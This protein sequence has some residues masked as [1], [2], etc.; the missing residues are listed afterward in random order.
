MVVKTELCSFSG[1]KIYPGH[2][3]RL[4]R[5]DGRQ[6]TFINAKSRASLLMR[7]KAAKLNW[8]QLYRRL[9][10]K[11]QQE[12]AQ[13][14]R[15]RTKKSAAPKP[16]EGASLEVIKAKRAQ[17]PEVRKKARDAALQEAKA[18]TEKKKKGGK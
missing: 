18:R 16:V 3:T 4:I 11:G 9:N 14:R 8:T 17:K 13:K 6:F 7:R 1:F 15:A 5:I 10:R 2:G 12:E